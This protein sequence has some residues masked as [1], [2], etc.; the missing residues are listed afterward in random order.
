MS[1][2]RPLLLLLILGLGAC[3]YI[4]P[5]QPPTTIYVMRHLNTPEGVQ[6]PDLTQEGQAAAER[7]ATWF[8]DAP[9]VTIFVSDTKRAR[10]TAAPLAERLGLQ[11][12]VYDPRNTDDLLLEVMKSA[13]PVLIV[14]HSNTVPD[15]VEKLSKARPAPLA[16]EDFGDIWRIAGPDR[17]V[18]RLK[19]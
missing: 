15:I 9:P 11:P 19:L 16:H 8:T 3:A 17:R 2:L 1:F 6:D 4:A 18:S 7:L 14:G 10:Q 13:T 12:I 5:L